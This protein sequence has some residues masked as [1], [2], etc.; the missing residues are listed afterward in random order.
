MAAIAAKPAVATAAPGK[1]GA[2]VGLAIAVVFVIGLL[3]VPL[4]GIMLDMLLVTSISLSLVDLLSALYTTNPLEF[5]SFP[6][7][8]LLLTLFRLALNVAS[9]RLILTHGA[10]GHVIQAFGEFVGGHP[11][12][13]VERGATFFSQ[14][15]DTGFD[16]DAAR[17]SQQVEHVGLP[18]VDARLYAEG[19]AAADEAFEKRLLRQEDLV[20]DLH[21][22]GLRQRIPGQQHLVPEQVDGQCRDPAGDRLRPDLAA[23]DGA[24]Q[25]GR[26]HAGHDGQEIRVEVAELGRQPVHDVRADLVV[27]PCHPAQEGE[28]VTAQL[29]G[30]GDVVGDGDDA[31]AHRGEDQVGA[32]APAAVQHLFAGPRPVGDALHRDVRVADRGQLLPGGLQDRVPVPVVHADRLFEVDILSGLRGAD[33][34][35]GVQERRQADQ[36]DVHRRIG[37]ERG[38]LHQVGRCRPELP[39]RRHGAGVMAGLLAQRAVPRVHHIPPGEGLGRVVRGASHAQRRQQPPLQYARP[40]LAGQPRHDRAEQPVREV[41]VVEGVQRR[42]RQLL[43]VQP[44]EQRVQGAP[45][46]PLP[47]VPVRLP[48]Y[49]T[50][51]PE[52]LAQADAAHRGARQVRLQR[53]VQREPAP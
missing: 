50:D 22:R 26:H 13:F 53:I 33:E 3:I 36:H 25:D 45:G 14:A 16:G 19:E 39:G 15:L 35:R 11:A 17:L 37:Q 5:S 46:R 29:A 31:P 43:R 47:P 6:G 44:G 10:A 9:T 27:S 7:L 8:L 23:G 42:V 52:Q 18:K 20:D 12:H 40:P 24:F 49:A 32:V 51:V 2:E 28:D 1:G 21:G 30:V 4:P 38:P 48:L 41:R 34:S